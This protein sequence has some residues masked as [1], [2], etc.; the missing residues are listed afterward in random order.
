LVPAI[1]AA[2]ILLR[3][4]GLRQW[5]T[6]FRLNR[7]TI[8]EERRT[9]YWT[10]LSFA[11]AEAK[12]LRVFGLADWLVGHTLR[13]R[14]AVIEPR[15]ANSAQRIRDKWLTALI[16]FAVLGTAF[17]VVGQGSARR[18]DGLEIE[19]M[20]LS[21]IWAMLLT[22]AG[23]SGSSGAWDSVEAVGAVPA[24]E[25]YRDLLRRIDA[26]RSRAAGTAASDPVWSVPS[27]RFEDVSFAYPSG[28]RNVLDGVDL[29]VR[30]GELLAVVGLNGTGKSTLIKVLAGLY[31]PTGGRVLV[32]GTDLAEFA[33]REYT[34]WREAISVVFQDFV[35]YQLSARENITLGRGG[36]VDETA[37]A[38][39]ARESGFERVLSRLPQGWDTP[40]SA[41]RTSGVDLSGGQWQQL[42]V[43]RSLYA[44][45]TGARI[46][47]LDEPTAHLDVRTEYEV[48]RRIAAARTG[49]GTSGPRASVILISHRL[50]TVRRADRIVLLDGGR[51]TES[52]SHEELMA[53]DGG[54]AEMFRIQAER[55][56]GTAD[57]DAPRQSKEHV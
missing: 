52:G 16:G 48:F 39:A 37:L 1:L 50:S 51:I 43:A 26:E 47:V 31:R 41:S 40:L 54:Y 38:R 6:F 34:P 35:K 9:R 33:D 49:T 55:F 8:G 12:E 36:D 13:H 56:T 53:L 28:A 14:R 46:L 4:V 2:G 21:S 57:D 17:V 25:A 30:P 3:H 22:A 32:D 27:V 19:A 29:E 24:Y 7:A 10:D 18:A 20:V 5:L 42:V 15:N 11:P 44:L 23:T 45:A